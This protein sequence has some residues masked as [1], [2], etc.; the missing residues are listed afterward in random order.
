MNRR[1]LENASGESGC[2]LNGPAAAWFWFTVMTTVGYGNQSPTTRG[3]RLLIYLVGFVTILA[4]AGTLAT[5]G[6]IVSE[7]LEDAVGRFLHPKFL[8]KLSKKWISCLFW[9][10]AYYVW[11]FAIGIATVRWKKNRLED[12]EFN[13][14]EGY[15][16]A[17]I[18]TTTVSGS[19]CIARGPV[20]WQAFLCF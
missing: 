14:S 10:C 20:L 13:F 15:W 4:F 16:F 6:Y 8:S 9:G 5:A 12:D 3:G 1:A 18:S 7:L 17:Y 11:M 19:R 2:E